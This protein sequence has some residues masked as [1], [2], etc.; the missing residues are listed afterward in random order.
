ME[1]TKRYK[2]NK[3]YPYSGLEL[4]CQMY[5]DTLI[6]YGE[7]NIGEQFIVIKNEDTSVASFVLNGYHPDNG[8]LFKCIYIDI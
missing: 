2:K 8:G 7:F 5:K 1:L 3:V 4:D 6:E